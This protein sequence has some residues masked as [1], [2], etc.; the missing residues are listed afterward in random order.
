M[1]GIV[2]VSSKVEY[3]DPIHHEVSLSI[4]SRDGTPC[5]FNKF[6]GDWMEL[7]LVFI[8]GSNRQ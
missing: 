5:L 7:R 3:P 4:V 8:E 6:P 1:L 2:I